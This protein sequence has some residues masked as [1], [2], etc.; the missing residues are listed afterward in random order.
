MENS[1][2]RERAILALAIDQRS[3][4]SDLQRPHRA[5]DDDVA[6][7]RNE[8]LRLAVIAASASS[9]ASAPVKSGVQFASA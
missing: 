2:R 3:A 6:V 7:P 8:F 9:S 4:L 1:D 5:D